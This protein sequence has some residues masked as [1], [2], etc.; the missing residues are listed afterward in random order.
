MSSVG[1]V[2]MSKLSSAPTNRVSNYYQAQF[3]YTPIKR[4]QTNYYALYKKIYEEEGVLGFWFVGCTLPTYKL[5]KL[6]PST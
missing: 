1:S 2:C 5:G 6:H 4:N 3:Y